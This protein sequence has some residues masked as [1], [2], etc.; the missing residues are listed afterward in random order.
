MF[1]F[2]WRSLE[3]LHFPEV[4]PLS[5]TLQI[6]PLKDTKSRS[7]NTF[8][9]THTHTHTHTHMHTHI[10]T[11]SH[12][13]ICRGCIDLPLLESAGFEAAR[14]RLGS[15]LCVP[16]LTSVGSGPGRIEPLKI[17]RRAREP[18]SLLVLIRTAEIGRSRSQ[19]SNIRLRSCLYRTCRSLRRG[20][21]LRISLHFGIF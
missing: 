9:N 6:G 1:S 21:M 2:R 4:L 10:H 3:Y 16:D 8:G 19:K 5:K 18:P 20:L 17:R 12:S 15:S 7:A 13:L 11:C 14:W